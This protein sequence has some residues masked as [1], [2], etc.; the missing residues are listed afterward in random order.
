MPALLDLLTEEF[1]SGEAL[2]RLLGVSRAAVHKEA[3]RLLEEGY[4]LEVGRKGYRVRPGTP[5]P[6]LFHPQGRFGRPYRY[7]GRVGS[8]QDA[9]RAWAEEGAPEGALVLSEVQE[10]GRGRRGRPWQSRPGDSLTFS[11]LLRP[12]LPLAALGLL[13]LLSGLALWEA[14]GVGGLKWPNDLLAPDGRKL[15]GVLLEAKVEGEEVA[16]ALLGV[17]VNVAWAPQGAAPLLEFGAFSRRGILE[18]FL[19]RLEALFPLLEDPPSFLA[20]YREASYTLG[21]RVR[22][23]TPKGPVEGVAEAVLPDGSLVVGGVRVAAGEVALLP[24]I[25]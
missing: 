12:S 6:H 4:P 24:I 18:A 14:V 8:T 17:G 2:A 7:L 20:R 9:L 25:E 3:H 11:L 22:V 10:R 19:L 21:R 15:A 5:L 23:E 1:Q 16:Y 13:P